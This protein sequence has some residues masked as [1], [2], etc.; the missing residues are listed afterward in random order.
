[1]TLVIRV[2]P[3]IVMEFRVGENGYEAD[4]HRRIAFCWPFL[5]DVTGD[6]TVNYKTAPSCSEN[7]P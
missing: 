3:D 2:L 4:V 1:M 6:K 7:A 5:W